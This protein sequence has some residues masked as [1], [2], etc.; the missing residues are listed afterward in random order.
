MVDRLHFCRE[1]G[2]L[3]KQ[4]TVLIITDSIDRSKALID[5]KM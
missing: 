5:E 1:V 3:S 4:N 2:I